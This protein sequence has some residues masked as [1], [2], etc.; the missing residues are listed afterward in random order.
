MEIRHSGILGARNKTVT[1]ISWGVLLRSDFSRRS[2]LPQTV[3]RDQLSMQLP[4]PQLHAKY[5]CRIFYYL[6]D[7]GTGSSAFVSPGWWE[8][9][10]SLVVTRQT[11]DTGLD[12]NEAEL[13]VLILSISLEMLTDGN[14][15]LDQ[16][17]Q[18]FWDLWCKAIRLE[19]SKNLVTSNNLDLCNTVRISED[20]TNLRWS[21]AF[22]CKFA[23][24]V[25]DLLGGCLQ[26]RR[27]S[28]GVWNGGG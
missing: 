22:L 15:L 26:P 6:C 18:I 28:S 1:E 11:V 12:E 24:L 17:V 10:N 5:Q 21:C 23:N 14:S 3:Q 2:K 25:D 27:R 16:H 19:D 8:N 13:G 4:T 9:T 20:N 7:Q